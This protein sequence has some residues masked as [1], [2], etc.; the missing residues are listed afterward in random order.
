[1][2]VYNEFI[3][4][5]LETTGLNSTYDRIVQ[6]S[7]VRFKKGKITNIFS[8]YIKADKEISK[9]AKKVNQISKLK[10][11]TAPKEEKVMEQVVEFLLNTL[12]G[13]IPLVAHNGLTFDILFLTK[14]LDRYGYPYKIQLVDTFKESKEYIDSSQGYKL[15]NLCDCLGIAIKNAHDAECDAIACGELLNNIIKKI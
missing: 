14:A 2:L 10:L 3:A 9:E 1:M 15:V 6:I 5:D 4:F 8:S 13:E 7:L 11:L 12:S